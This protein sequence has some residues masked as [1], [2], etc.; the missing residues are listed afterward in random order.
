MKKILIFV[1]L[2][3]I[4]SL[5]GEEFSIKIDKD[6]SLNIP[7]PKIQVVDE[8]NIKNLTYEYSDDD[9]DPTLPKTE[10]PESVKFSV[11]SKKYEE[12]YE[13]KSEV[14]SKKDVY[15]FD[16]TDYRKIK[17]LA[18][19]IKNAKYQHFDVELLLSI[20]KK[21]S[22]F[23]PNVKSEVGAIGLMQI[24]PDT[25]EWL[26]LKN[27]SKLYDPDTNIKYGIK[28]LRYLFNYFKGKIPKELSKEDINDR[29]V[30][31]SIAAYN[32]G[33]GNVEKYDKPP[34]NGIPPFK[35]TVD[36]VEKVS[37]YF[38]K[39]EDLNIPKK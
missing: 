38:V 20:I 25:A 35:E 30:L 26:G 7:K 33:P 24:M 5:E 15:G 1:M 6:I 3:S 37:F 28:Y 21:E 18:L 8:S 34:Y 29:D 14:K 22:N 16:I 2:T 32:A 27:T 19:V 11:K 17:Y 39:F 36:Y 9:F 31:K 4:L 12:K 10:P 13:E 23:N